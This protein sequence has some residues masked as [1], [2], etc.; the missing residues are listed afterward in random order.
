[1]TELPDSYDPNSIEPKWQ[2]EW[3]ERDVY[4]FDPSESDTQYVIDTPPP[5]PSGNL[6]LGHALGW[7]YIDFVARYRRLKGDAVLFPQGWDCHGLPTEVKVEEVNDIHRTDVP[8]DE[9]REMCIDWTEDR[10]DEMKA[11][12]QELGFSQDWDSE[13]RT[14]DPEYWGKTQESFSEMAD[15]GMVYRDEH[16]VNWCPRCETAIAD[17]EVENIDREGTLHYVTFDGVDNGDIEIAT[18]RPELLAACVGI[19]VSPDDDRY[20]DRIGDTFEVP[21]F[22]QD[23][24]LLADDDVDADFGSGAVM[25]CTFG[26]KQDVEWWMDHDLD[27]RTV[28]T[29]DGHLNEAAG[30]FAGLAI[31]D[32]KTQVAEELDDQGYLNDTEPT[33][34]SVGSCWRCDTAIEILSKEQWFVEVDQDRI[35]DAAADA[36]W[37]PEHMHDRLVEWT[38]GMDWDWVISRQRVF[39]TPIPAWECNE[40]GHWE[41]AGR[42]QAPVDPTEDDP[43]VEACPECGGDDWAGETDVMDTWMDSSITPLHLSGWPEGTTLDEFESVDL[44][45]QGHD[46]IRTWAFYTLLRTGALTDEQ[47]WDDVLVNGMVFGEDGNK[48]SKSRGNFVQPDEAIA[49]YSADAVRQ[50]LALGGRPG[51]DVQFQWKEVKSASRF[52]TKLWNITKFSTGHFDE[53]TPAIQDPAYR[54]ADRWLLSELST[55]C[56]DVDEAMSEYRFDRALRSLREFAWEDLA[57]DYVELVKGRLYNGRP[58]ERAAAEHTLY[59]AVTAVTR[60]LAPFSPHTT[61]EIWQSLPGTEGSVHAA[62]FPSVEYRDADAELAGKRI[63]EVAREIRAWKSDQ[64]MPLNADLDRVELY[65]DDSDDDAARLDT[66]DL[67]ET[68]NAP[69]RLI[70][71]R[72]DVELVPVDV[73]GDDSEIGPEFRSDA[74][75]VMEAIAAAD[76]A[77]IQAQIHSGDTVTVEADGESFDLDAD[78]L[79]VTEEYRASSGEEVTVIEASFGTVIIYE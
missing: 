57:D 31:D 2:D 16:P 59:T 74:G 1:M 13:Y 52:L 26:D 23:V 49:E 71:G 29:E 72:P 27:L 22:G 5:Y 12:M 44:R 48:M 64:G 76:P 45:P 66:Y 77:A 21:L 18:T 10:I 65:F 46:I 69:I 54:D 47:P 3:Q 53:D 41:I 42:E 73:D 55:V 51:S 35:L 50:A 70:D 30:E 15:A 24:E 75:T 79:T 36:E 34:Q 11:T 8:S 60:L 6:H 63:A 37:V 43:A 39:A 19:V 56:E 61:E 4:R 40:C 9:F 67:S 28:F 78:W 14:M 33:E 17:A 68:V 7:S 58:G 62:T 32:A 38:E 25:V 20:A